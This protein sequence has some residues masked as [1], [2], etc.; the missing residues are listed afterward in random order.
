M[1]VGGRSDGGEK[2]IQFKRKLYY[3]VTCLV[4]LHPGLGA[5]LF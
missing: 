3:T 5:E 1:H 2:T 4:S